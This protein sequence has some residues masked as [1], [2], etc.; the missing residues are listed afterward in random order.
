MKIRRGFWV[1]FVGGGSGL[2]GSGCIS[3]VDVKF[4]KIYIYTFFFWGGGAWGQVG[5]GGG[6]GSEWM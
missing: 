3:E 4:K 2:W 1:G 5:G 6:G